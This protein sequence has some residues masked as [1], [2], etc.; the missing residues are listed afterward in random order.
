MRA[1][2]GSPEPLSDEGVIARGMVTLL[3]ELTGR[4]ATRVTT[5]ICSDHVVVLL[6][7]ALTKAE[8]LL[9]SEGHQDKVIAG[10]LAIKD[11]LRPQAPAED[12]AKA[13]GAEGAAPHWLRAAYSRESA[14]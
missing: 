12:D 1:G 10:R 7:E 14:A 5:T 9:A 2:K 13:Q 3:S 8:M 6:Y 4:G 11:L